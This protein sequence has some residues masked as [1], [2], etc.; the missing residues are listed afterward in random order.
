MFVWPPWTGYRIIGTSQ[1]AEDDVTKPE[2]RIVVTVQCSGRLY[3][4]IDLTKL[5]MKQ[6]KSRPSISTKHHVWGSRGRSSPILNLGTR[7]R[8]V[9]SFTP[10]PPH[11]DEPRY[12]LDWRLVGTVWTLQQEKI[13]HCRESNLGVPAHSLVTVQ[14]IERWLTRLMNDEF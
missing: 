11:P 13:L 2:A 14:V 8:S 5:P 10:Q 3:F 7:W 6:R 12:T 1:R 9:V 4:M